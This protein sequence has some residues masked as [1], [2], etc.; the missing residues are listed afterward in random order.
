MKK[1]LKTGKKVLSVFMA[2]LMVMTAWVFFEPTKA[3]ALTAGSYKVTVEWKVT[4]KR[5]TGKLNSYT[6]RDNVTGNKDEKDVAGFS[7]FYKTNNGLGTEKEV[8]WDIN[9]STY[10]GVTTMGNTGNTNSGSGTLKAT[11]TI[12]GFPTSLYAIYDNNS[13]S[14]FGLGS[15]GYEITAIKVANSDGTNEKTLWKGTAH[16]ESSTDEYY[17]TIASTKGDS[18]GNHSSYGYVDTSSTWTWET[19]MPAPTEDTVTWN[20]TLE[21]M[22][23]PKSTV[24]TKASQYVSVTAAKDQYGVNMSNPTWEI[25][26]DYAK[27][28]N[29]YS[30]VSGGITLSG[31][32]ASAGRYIYISGAANTGTTATSQ[33][34]T[35][36]ACWG[37]TKI[38]QEF[39]LTDAKYDL[40]FKNIRNDKY[41]QQD[42]VV[43]EAEV[44]HGSWPSISYFYTTSSQKITAYKAE[45]GD[46]DYK[47]TGWS[48]ARAV[49][50]ADTEYTAQYDDG[51]FV[52]A[53][54]K[55]VNDAIADANEF[56]INQSNY[57]IKYT[58]ESRA[59]LEGAIAAV[60]T[61]L[62]RTRQADVD[63]FAVD[64]EAAMEAMDVNEFTVIF[65][66]NDNRVLKIEQVSYGKDVT[67][68]S[69]EELA[70]APD[71]EFHYAFK[72]WDKP[73]TNITETQMIRA[74]F[75]AVAHQWG[76]EIPVTATCQHGSGTK[77]ICQLCEYEKMTTNDDII[78]HDYT[79][80]TLS[81]D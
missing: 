46:K 49:V 17:L 24:T 55:A 1:T 10:G 5:D 39:K 75:E 13:V 16:L 22:T 12:S 77:V 71:A 81:V 60:V 19:N 54:Y 45:S 21:D 29:D 25:S 44:Y 33:Q 63:K 11:A 4:D 23:C 64:I 14:V 42:D 48:T 9:N 80:K 47:F 41:E 18:G 7:I 20:K 3:S 36:S 78:A 30:T 26:T 74:S 69:T 51:T 15:G 32:T 67:A 79:K 43:M 8:Y 56:Y 52:E 70:K 2:M 57:V 53:N 40:T 6:G 61:G 50:T 59:R 58:A 28:N 31:Y 62:G 37:T 66:D 68:P 65:L 76:E 72:G 38:S 73:L 35:V 27:T 34:V